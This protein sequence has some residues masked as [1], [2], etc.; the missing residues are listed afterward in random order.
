M[1][2]YEA[3]TKELE[4]IY[5]DRLSKLPSRAPIYTA[6]ERVPMIDRIRGAEHVDQIYKKDLDAIYRPKLRELKEKY[7]DHKR[8][9]LIGNGP[10]L[11]ETDL[12]MLKDE[13][14][15]A[16]NGFFLKAKD[17]DWKPTFYLVEDH[18]VAED[19]APWIN[20]FKGSTKLFPAYLGYA[21]P[22][23]ED[24]IF[25][26]HR[27]RKSYPDGYDFSMEADKIT[28]TGCTVTFS[29]MQI[30]AY[31][32][33]EEIYLIGVDASYDIPADAQEGQ[34]YAV[35][36]L[37]M[38]SD[39]TNHFDPD[40]FGKGFR[41]HDPQVEKM[42][43]AYS[44]AR[45]TLEGTG[46]TIYNATV[47]GMLEVF[48]RR[49]F[50]SIFPEAKSP[51]VVAAEN[52]AKQ[53]A[54]TPRML[55]IDMTAMGNGTAT[56]EIK[57]TLFAGWPSEQILQVAKH[58]KDQMALVTMGEDDTYPAKVSTAEEVTA[59]IDAFD[60]E[61]IMYRQVPNTSEL[62]AFAMQTI[63]RLNV[64][65]VTWLMDDWPAEMERNDPEQWAVHGPDLIKL[66]EQSAVR[67][68]ICDAMSKAFEER[69]GHPF[70]A[71]AN[72]VNP[73]DWA[74][75]RHQEG[76]QLRVRY[77]GG[78]APNMTLDSVL[79]VAEA[80]ENL[81]KK[82]KPVSF[83][84]NTQ[85]WWHRDHGD[86]F[87]K[88][89]FTRI[90]TTN[91]P[92][93]EYREWLREADAVVIAYNFNEETRRYVQYSMANKTPECLASGAVVFAHGPADFATIA[94]LG[95]TDAAAVVTKPEVSA[96]EAELVSLLDNPG[97]RNQLA[98]KARQIA[99]RDRNVVKL[100]DALRASI[101][102]AVAGV[103]QVSEFI[104]KPVAAP[105]SGID[106]DLFDAPLHT[107]DSLE[108]MQLLAKKAGAKSDP[109]LL[110]IAAANLLLAPK[111]TL[112]VL[113][114]SQVRAAVDKVLSGLPASNPDKTHFLRV[115]SFVA[116]RLG[117]SKTGKHAAE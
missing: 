104:K 79:R 55:V 93:E 30:A 11:N 12:S 94:Y 63:E 21:F 75:L 73:V 19:R 4:E 22:A 110:K 67:L 31:L 66:L 46:Q 35:G 86:K 25:Y 70:K 106:Q 117:A 51:E 105:I 88:F 20:E 81:A 82:G 100:R 116:A 60:P 108:F 80:V 91:R 68:S 69:Y 114:S 95:S 102:Q 8:C 14:T 58:G 96:L 41:W 53:L 107:P 115:E 52:E 40:Y 16:V 78:L 83:E 9:F 64:P 27:P 85:K 98:E 76:K 15:F 37:D 87:D 39:D 50:H 74:E 57:S 54:K 109:L 77:A 26:N 45:R 90:E 34:D 33:F 47:G 48:E 23:A 112:S 38:K 61:V 1:N 99:F 65:L 92:T 89:K 5:D 13:V 71:Y 28:Y 17:L 29:M 3:T 101:A 72:G 10:S 111:D 59:A 7:K 36:V 18:L 62:H 97:K 49:S 56:G 103:P 44:E 32:G 42:V 2:L 43:E 84:I 113:G 24:T 6:T